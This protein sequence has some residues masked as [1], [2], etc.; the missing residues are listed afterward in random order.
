MNPALLIYLIGVSVFFLISLC[1]LG[2]SLHALVEKRSGEDAWDFLVMAGA[3]ALAG[4][5][6]PLVAVVAAM[7]FVVWFAG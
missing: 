6:W 1:A 4:V 5:L 7:R 3:F 2:G